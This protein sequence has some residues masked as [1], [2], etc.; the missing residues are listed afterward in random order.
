[1]KYPATFSDDLKYL[2]TVYGWN[3]EDKTDI[4]SA[5]IGCPDTVRFFTNLAAAHRAG[6]PTPAG[7]G[8]TALALWCLDKGLPDPFG[9]AFNTAALDAA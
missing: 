9:P 7:E 6:Y 5:F 8:F 1:L 3:E 4:R 2:T